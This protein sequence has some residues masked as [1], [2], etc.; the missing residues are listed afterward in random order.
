MAEYFSKVWGNRQTPVVGVVV[1]ILY[2]LSTIGWLGIM[3]HKNQLF[4]M[5]VMWQVIVTL[6]SATV[7][8]VVFSEKLSG[9]QWAGAALA[10]MSV[11]MLLIE[12]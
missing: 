12:K 3:A 6:I 8:L 1:V 11:S 5:G 2:G 7:G 4:V 9:W 10:V